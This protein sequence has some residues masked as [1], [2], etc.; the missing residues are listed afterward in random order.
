MFYLT[1]KKY[2]CYINK[3]PY[4]QFFLPVITYWTILSFYTDLLNYKNSVLYPLYKK[5][6]ENI[7]NERIYNHLTGLYFFQKYVVITIIDK[8]NVGYKK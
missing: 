2:F 5:E 1:V 8:K 6:N 3:K 4:H 7:F